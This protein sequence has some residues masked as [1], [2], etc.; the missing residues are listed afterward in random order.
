MNNSDPHAQLKEFEELDAEAEM[1]V[2]KISILEA[3]MLRILRQY[4][5]GTFI[6]EKRR[7]QPRF[8]KPQGSEL[9][10]EEDG[11]AFAVESLEDSE[12]NKNSIQ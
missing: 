1:I 7:G 6:V 11:Y 9:L 2:V 10:K 4:R 3:A 5:F 8:V 12:M